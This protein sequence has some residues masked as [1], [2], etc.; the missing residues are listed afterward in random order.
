MEP[1]VNPNFFFYTL[2]TVLLG[3]VAYFIRQLHSDF[4]RVVRD[5]SE[6]KA[7][8][9]I[10]KTEFKGNIELTIF[11]FLCNNWSVIFVFLYKY[12]TIMHS[13]RLLI[14][15][16]VYDRI[17]WLLK[18]FSKDEVR[19]VTEEDDFQ[20]TQQYLEKELNEMDSGKASFYSLDEAEK[21]LE[22]TIRKHEDNI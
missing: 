17:M 1:V 21:K 7:T 6:V 8:M 19:I 22:N 10:L 13:I 2:I 16:K 12:R 9:S 15:D 3:V 18:K 4:K 5:V 14:S 20:L 11:Y